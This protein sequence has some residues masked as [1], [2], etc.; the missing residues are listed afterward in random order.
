MK[1]AV[2]FRNISVH[3]YD[4]IDWVIVFDICRNRLGDFAE[5]ARSVEV[6]LPE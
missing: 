4:Q 6:K 2:G 3:T 1:R 5:F